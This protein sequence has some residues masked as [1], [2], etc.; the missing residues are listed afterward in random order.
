MQRVFLGAVAA[1][2]VSLG[3]GSLRAAS[4]LDFTFSPTPANYDPISPTY[5]SGLADT[6][7]ISVSYSSTSLDGLR[8]DPNLLFWNTGY[9]DLT[10]VA[11]ATTQG[12]LAEIKF[13]A[14]AGYEVELQSFLLAGYPQQDL[15]ASILRIL[16][17]AGTVLWDQ[18]GT[19]VLGQQGKHSVYTPNLR[20]STLRLQWGREW[21]IGIDDVVFAQVD[22]TAIPEPTG[23]AMLAIGGVA[24]AAFA[25]RRKGA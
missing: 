15:V 23:V 16:D 8:V 2:A 5:G 11:F 24:V 25:A 21:N 6:P 1:L 4:V 10:G 22:P 20:A 17:G 14:A 12:D 19:T 9:G 18:S 3:A 13:Q 7:D